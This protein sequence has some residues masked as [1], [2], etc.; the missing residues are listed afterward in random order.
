MHCRVHCSAADLPC[1]SG[2]RMQFAGS[3]LGSV[4][5]KGHATHDL[6]YCMRA[7]CR[8]ILLGNGQAAWLL[9]GCKNRCSALPVAHS[10]KVAPKLYMSAAGVGSTSASNNSGATYLPSPSS[11]SCSSE[12]PVVCHGPLQYSPCTLAGMDLIPRKESSVLRH[13]K[14]SGMLRLAEVLPTGAS[15]RPVQSLQA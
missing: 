7:I 2:S 5:P 14:A 8:L 9:N 15:A 12:Y 1:S 6:K 4:F 11:Q 10:Y 13:V 3:D